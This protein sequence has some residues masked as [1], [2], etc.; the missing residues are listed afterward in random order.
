MDDEWNVKK[1]HNGE[2]L[3]RPPSSK[4]PCWKCPKTVGYADKQRTP[5]TGRKAEL[6]AKNLR[7]YRIYQQLQATS[8]KVPVEVDA[9]LARKLGVIYDVMENERRQSQVDLA[10]ALVINRTQK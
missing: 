2:P 4:P 5:A 10:M 8:G 7:V 1:L 9:L 6:T 3:E